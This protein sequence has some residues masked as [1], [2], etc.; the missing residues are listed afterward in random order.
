M[1]GTDRPRPKH[2]KSDNRRVD[3][4]NGR[5]S[6]LQGRRDSSARG[7]R[8]Q[9][10]CLDDRRQFSRRLL[11]PEQYFRDPRYP[12]RREFWLDAAAKQGRLIICRCARCR[13]LVRY[14]AV[15]L[16]PLLGPA[17]RAS[18]DP[19]FPCGKCGRTD[20]IRVTCELPNAGDSDSLDV[21]RPAGIRRT[22]LWR[23]VKLGDEV[24]NV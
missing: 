17:H 20:S 15:D 7:C 12:D 3:Q 23:T 11:M 1:R 21:R 18:V 5:A 10:G 6:G 8:P 14:L 9:A 13:R 4:G 24:G 2:S 22:Q 16:S 19:P